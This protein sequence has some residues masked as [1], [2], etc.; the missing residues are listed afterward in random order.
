MSV[1]IRVRNGMMPDE[2][3]GEGG[4]TEGDD[5]GDS[6]DMID[7]TGV[8]DLAGGHCLVHQAA[9][10]NMTVVVDQGV[11]YIPNTSFDEFDS[12]SIKFWEA[13]VAGTTL[14]RT[15]AIDS[16]SSGQ[17]RIDLIALYLDPGLEPDNTGSDVAE[18]V[19]VKGTPGAGTPVTPAFHEVFGRVTVVN[20]ETAITT[21]E[22]ADVRTQVTI[23]NEFLNGRRFK[24]VLR[25]VAS[26]TTPDPS[27]DT[28]DVYEITALAGNAVF[29][30]IVG[31]P[32]NRQSMLIIIKD[33]GSARTLTWHSS[34]R[35]VGTYLPT[36]TVAGKV[37]YVGGVW[38]A[39]ASKFDVLATAQE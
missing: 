5:R 1:N 13:V 9:S 34:Y 29:P 33:N 18:L 23:K 21:N 16:N 4:V 22:V 12:D 19:V 28:E 25:Q 35:A 3:S 27:F 15:L 7:T 38:N 30:A 11:V 37:V 10:P 26:D 32:T 31:T 14:S 8:V 24:K 20:G 36:T 17:T 39:A 2:Y 6:S